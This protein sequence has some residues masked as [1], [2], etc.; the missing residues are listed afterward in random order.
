MTSMDDRSVASDALTER[1]L[2]STPRD[3]VLHI[4]G[5]AFGALPADLIG[6]ST[7]PLSRWCIIR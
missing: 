3:A 7:A 2:A 1:R 4:D 5:L 6:A